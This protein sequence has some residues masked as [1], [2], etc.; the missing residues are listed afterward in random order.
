MFELLARTKISYYLQACEIS[1]FIKAN[2][3]LSAKP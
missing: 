1:Q 2:N 3:V